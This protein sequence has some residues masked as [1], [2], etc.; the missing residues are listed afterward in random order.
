MSETKTYE[1]D[2]KGFRLKDLTLDE[3]D[4]VNK[5]ISLE[6]KEL[7]VSNDDSK[8]F[9]QLV[10]EPLNGDTGAVDFGKCTERTA[11]EV[12]KDFFSV[13]I[14]SGRSLK[15]FFKTLAQEPTRPL[16][17]INR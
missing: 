5:I 6:G 15:E 11:L 12:L 7:A 17:N 4:E 3:A 2:G 13:K 8:R 14:E 16:Q 1:I 9:L 10:L